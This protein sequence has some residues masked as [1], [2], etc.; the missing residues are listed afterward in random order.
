MDD[1][2]DRTY[3]QNDFVLG[4]ALQVRVIRQIRPADRTVIPVVQRPLEAS[5]TERLPKKVVSQTALQESATSV[6]NEG[7]Q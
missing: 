3:R 2:D 1:K 6:K 4:I 7:K 5:P